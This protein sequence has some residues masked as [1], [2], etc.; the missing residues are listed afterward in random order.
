MAT[1]GRLAPRCGWGPSSIVRT[2]PSTGSRY[3]PD[4]KHFLTDGE[5]SLL[6]VWDAAT[7]RVVRRIDPAVGVLADFAITS[8]G[9]LVMALGTTL[10][11]GRG[12]VHNV[13][14]T[15]LE[16]GRP[17]DVGSWKD[18]G[19]TYLELALCADRQIVAMVG[20]SIVGASGEIRV[21]DAWTGAETCRFES[22]NRVVDHIEFSRDGKRLAIQTQGIDFNNLNR[23]LRIYDLPQKKEI[24]VIK[25]DGHGLGRPVLSP[26]GSTVAAALGN[27]LFVW[28]V[29]TGERIPFWYAQVGPVSYSA[30]GRSLAG[31]GYIGRLALF[32]LRSRRMTFF[33]DTKTTQP[34]EVALSPDGQTLVANGGSM[35]LH[36]WE[37]K[38]RRDRFAMPDAHCDS[39]S[40]LF[41]TPDGKAIVTGAADGSIRVWD[42]RD[43]RQVRRWDPPEMSMNEPPVLAPDGTLLV[44]SWRPSWGTV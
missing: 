39:L 42:S 16:T 24:R 23:D 22:V 2:L 32:D 29:E 6:R 33:F 19:G 34:T 41:I 8:R 13:T 28:V 31:I 10:E 11:P 20:A 44:P 40:T 12:F 21:V 26:D 25:L 37:I 17:V 3:A 30:D 4:G 18:D 9:K 1:R 38:A 43:G 36:S 14:M 35:V 7:G 27:H 15:E 5:D